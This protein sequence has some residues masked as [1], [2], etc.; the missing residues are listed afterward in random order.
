MI[1]NILTKIDFFGATFG[2]TINK[3][4]K[5]KTALGGI[6]SIMNLTIIG[7]FTIF[8]GQDFYYR[9]NPMVYLNTIV[10]DKY[11]PPLVLKPEN[12]TF[13]WRIESNKLALN[14][15]NTLY[16]VM[17]RFRYKRDEKDVLDLVDDIPLEMTKCNA[18][19]TKLKEFKDNFK[20]DDWY[21]FDWT[22]NV[23]DGF[24]FGGFWDGDY[25]NGFQTLLYL[26]ENGGVYNASNP[27]CTK[28]E[29][30]REFSNLYKGLQISIMY[31]QYFFAA[32]DVKDPLRITYKNYYYYFNLKTFKID[33]LFFNK[34]TLNDDRGWILEDTKSSSM[35]S[36]N[37]IQSDQNLNEIFDGS[38]SQL[39]E[40][41][42]YMEKSSQMIRR[43]YMKI[44]DV[45]AKV[46]GIIKFIMTVFSLLD[47]FFSG[48]FFNV[49]IFDKIFSYPEEGLESNTK[50]SQFDM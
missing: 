9:I 24:T 14:F 13:A 25:V 18:E 36:L 35:L 19:N 26:C 45:S 31:P 33:R 7:I 34:V 2:F 3:R 28:L 48:H 38:S 32:D 16:P 50:L 20:L 29:D 10:P 47:M 30:Y 39:Y 49:F 15:S 43:S 40:F 6:F 1:K 12:F 44:Q 37:R 22:K 27:K 11:D 8:F 4:E 17:R 42:L 23:K 5:Y 46:G 41:N 21:C